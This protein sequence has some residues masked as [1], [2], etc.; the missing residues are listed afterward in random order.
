MLEDRAV[1]FA[2]FSDTNNQLHIKNTGHFEPNTLPELRKKGRLYIVA[3][4]IWGTAAG[5]I[6]SHYAIH[7]IL[8]DFYRDYTETDL[9]K[10]LVK[11]IQ[12][13]NQ[14]IYERNQQTPNRRPLATTI[15]VALV[16]QNKL[17]IANI[18]DNNAYVSWKDNFEMMNTPSPAKGLGLAESIEVELAFRRMFPGDTLIL[19][20]GG[21][22]GYVTEKEIND[23]AKNNAPL[24]ATRKLTK[25]ARDNGCRD[26]VAVSITEILTQTVVQTPPTR[27]KLPEN[28]T[29][30]ALLTPPTP[31]KPLEVTPKPA[32]NEPPR[33][34]EA[35][36][37]RWI[38]V[39]SLLGL[40]L[41]VCIGTGV[42][43]WLYLTSSS[44]TSVVS[45][46]EKTA[47]A[48]FTI[49]PITTLAVSEDSPTVTNT[50]TIETDEADLVEVSSP[51][52][53][54]TEALLVDSLADDF[55]SQTPTVAPTA[56][57]T[58]F[59]TVELPPGCTNGARYL[60]DLTI[61]DGSQIPAGQSF[62]KVWSMTNNG[63]CPW[64]PGYTVRFIG[65]D[66]M[67]DEAEQFPPMIQPGVTIPLTVSMIAP[68]VPGNYQSSW[69]FHN[70]EGEPFGA[71]ISVVIEVTAPEPGTVTI[72]QN[73]TVLYNFIEQA[74]EAEWVSG[75]EITYT[76]ET[77]RIDKALVIPAPLG[78]VVIGPAELRGRR[79][80]ATDV[81][82]THPHQE[83][84][85]IEGRYE[86]DTP[87]ETTDELVVNLG[88]PQIAILSQDGVT[89]E[90]EFEAADGT[91]T[92]LMSEVMTPR[93]SPINKRL[94]LEGIQSGATGTFIF[95]VDGGAD[96]AY[97]WA[98]WLD[99]RLTRAK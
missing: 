67:H 3:D 95:R 41:L 86:I 34:E 27:A 49:T 97:D 26:H 82:L 47:V 74:N 9:E 53:T 36:T 16:H 66:P 68:S 87:L 10:R 90:I 72:N 18:G 40:A 75:E 15:M 21:L 11:V 71:E 96:T 69:Q 12:Q 44:E 14:T 83:I 48:T 25:I 17:T 38:L 59:P 58:P 31:P 77:G 98:L 8:H 73:E 13:T 1:K 62:D 84:G 52:A 76:P 29:W 46:P 99:L 92:T 50:P 57:P 81:L 93:D 70:L 54:P 60:E 20:N 78:L 43:G 91:K 19:C 94:P 88:F 56:T 35:N 61:P 32:V 23:T 64:V 79:E 2:Q 85:A 22:K 5:M 24:E 7:K 80:T 45:A 4:G 51:I 6:A 28:P 63:T 55:A 37:K 33:A 39:A 65:G 30:E 42:F 89:Y